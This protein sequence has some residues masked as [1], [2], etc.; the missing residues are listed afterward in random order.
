MVG[1]FR[2][3]TVL[4]S[5]E[6]NST[7]VQQ[8]RELTSHCLDTTESC[9]IKKLFDDDVDADADD[10][11]DGNADFGDDAHDDAHVGNDAVDAEDG[12]DT[13]VM[14][15]LTTTMMLML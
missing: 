12:D 10:G 7:F 2:N 1:E 15:M 6:R 4:C 9:Q 5:P 14:L 11:D 3:G 8:R 13:D